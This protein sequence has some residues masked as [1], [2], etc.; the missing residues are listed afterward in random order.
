M[1]GTPF[2]SL[3]GF[4]LDL[5]FE[6]LIPCSASPFECLLD[7]WN[8]K[9]PRLN[10]WFL[11]PPPG[12]SF[13]VIPSLPP[14]FLFL[15]SVYRHLWSPSFPHALHHLHQQ[16]LLAVAS[17]DTQTQATSHFLH[18]YHPVKSHHHFP[19]RLSSS[20]YTFSTYSHFSP[21]IQREPFK[22]K[23]KC[24]SLR[25]DVRRSQVCRRAANTLPTRRLA[26]PLPSSPSRPSTQAPRR[27]GALHL[28]PPWLCAC[29]SGCPRSFPG[30]RGGSASH[31]CLALSSNTIVIVW[32]SLAIL[33]K[34]TSK[35]LPSLILPLSIY[36]HLRIYLFIY[37]LLCHLVYKLEESNTCS[38]LFRAIHA[39]HRMVSG[40]L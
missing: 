10:S 19:S 26:P 39:A 33:L 37:C 29:H 17:K 32:V 7:I 3:L 36:S 28:P 6:Y 11:Q 25:M 27:W 20:P 34:I 4:S 8:L 30:E 9:Q 2:L 40:T 16:I 23:T 22:Q 24:H 38:I 21:N 13:Q 15:S 35:T 18:G 12:C 5:R 14:L 31:C 1:V